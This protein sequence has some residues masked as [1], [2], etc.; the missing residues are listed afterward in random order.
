MIQGL[1]SNF[2]KNEY[3]I[4]LNKSWMPINAGE[5]IKLKY[6]YADLALI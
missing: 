4:S 2:A 1:W 5:A 6:K 3:C